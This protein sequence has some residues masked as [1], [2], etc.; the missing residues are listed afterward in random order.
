MHNQYMLC[1]LFSNIKF[2]RCTHSFAKRTE[3]HL[4]AS[5]AHSSGKLLNYLMRQWEKKRRTKRIW[6]IW[7]LDCNG[8]WCKFKRH[9]LPID[10]YIYIESDESSYITVKRAFTNPT[11]MQ[12]PFENQDASYILALWDI[13]IWN[14]LFKP[15]EN[16]TLSNSIC[17][18]FCT[19]N[20]LTHIRFRHR[21]V[22][23]VSRLYYMFLYLDLSFD[24]CPYLMKWRC[25]KYYIDIIRRMGARSTW[26]QIMDDESYVYRMYMPTDN[27]IYNGT[28]ICRIEWWRRQRRRWKCYRFQFITL[29]ISGQKFC[30]PEYWWKCKMIMS[31][32]IK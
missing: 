9:R 1:F 11:S 5:L 16:Y 2:Y 28:L 22:L 10:R 4:F 30:S 15:Y 7:S 26:R 6:S 27:D 32:S 31:F 12:H 18:G 8:V 21:I 23:Y 25:E 3:L 20:K 17:N 13:S 19:L 29:H 24:W 14:V